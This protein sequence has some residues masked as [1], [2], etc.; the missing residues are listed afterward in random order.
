M[1]IKIDT[2]LVLRYSSIGDWFPDG[3][4]TDRIEVQEMGNRIYEFLIAIHELVESELCR[5]NGVTSEQVD[6]WDIHTF[7][8]DGEPGDDPLCPYHKEHVFASKVERM[9]ANEMGVDW[10]SYNDFLTKF[11]LKENEY[12]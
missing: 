11:N 4:G 9:V 7:K 2:E 1:R 5:M 10:N 3:G 12:E 8:G 6:E